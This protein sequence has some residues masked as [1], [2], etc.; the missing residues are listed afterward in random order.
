[1]LFLIENM[2]T[3]DLNKE[4]AALIQLIDEPDETIYSQIKNR[5]CSYKKEAIPL[6]EYAWTHNLHPLAQKRIEVLL[7]KLRFENIVNDL[8]DWYALGASNLLMGYLLVSKYQYPHLDE[9]LVRKEIDK[10]RKEIWLELNSDLTALEKVK[11]FNKIFF[12]INKFEGDHKNYYSPL[13]SYIN[14]VLESRKGN[15]LALSMLLIILADMVEVPIYGVNLPEHFILAYVDISRSFPVKDIQNADVLFYIN[16][17]SGGAVFT[18][19]EIEA[20]LKQM[21][22]EPH[23]RY[24]QPCNNVEMI[25]RLLVNLIHS[26][27]SSGNKVKVSELEILLNIFD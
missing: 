19:Y 15:P 7:N 3:P 18:R 14:N 20:F 26:Y 2:N 16:P 11:V 9:N 21:N 27:N 10:I 17:F 12:D 13:N 24:F 23:S 25:K 22:I 6:L 1:L 8:S 5:I 4:L